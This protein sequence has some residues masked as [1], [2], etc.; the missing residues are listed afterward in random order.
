MSET[1][2]KHLA[3]LLRSAQSGDKE[4][5]R[6]LC[7]E[8]EQYIRGYFWAKFRDNAI[9]DDL[10]QETYVRLLKNLLTIRDKM[11]LQS[12]V[13]KVAFHVTQD[14]FRQTYRKQEEDIE[15]CY[16]RNGESN[17]RTLRPEA[18]ENAGDDAIINRIDLRNALKQLPQKS[19]DILLMKS[20]GYNYEEIS[21]E[22]GLSVSGVKMQIKRGLEQLKISLL[23]VTFIWFATT[24]LIRHL[25]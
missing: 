16:D 4:S 1:S 21:T 11:K 12:F 13:A 19:R 22:M 20:Q 7:H 2:K 3:R 10:A 18:F 23:I 8:L 9:V 25:N 15:A 17:E 6:L 24:I 14:H 5:L